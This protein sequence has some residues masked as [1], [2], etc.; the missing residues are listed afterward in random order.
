VNVEPVLEMS[1][2]KNALDN[3]YIERE[4]KISWEGAGQDIER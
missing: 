2:E 4:R 3:F 1:A